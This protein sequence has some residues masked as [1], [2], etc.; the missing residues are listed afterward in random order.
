[1][2]PQHHRFL[3]HLKTVQC[4]AMV[5]FTCNVKKIKGVALKNGDI[6]GTCKRRLKIKGIQ[7]KV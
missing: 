4:S 3:S 2:Y 7:A 5:P 1:M 6:G